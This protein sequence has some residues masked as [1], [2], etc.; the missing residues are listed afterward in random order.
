MVS[1]SAYIIYLKNGGQIEADSCRKEGNQIKYMIHDGEVG[2][3]IEDVLKIKEGT[4]EP[5]KKEQ[6]EEEA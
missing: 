6:K 4:E 1:F 5:M 3:G 2:I